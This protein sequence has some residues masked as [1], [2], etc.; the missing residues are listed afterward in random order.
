VLTGIASMSVDGNGSKSETAIA[1]SSV[2]E[3][4]KSIASG[5]RITGIRSW[6]GAAISFGRPVMMVHVSTASPSGEFHRSHSPAN[7]KT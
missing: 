4:H 1:G 5:G 3:S 2:V 7:A 6:I